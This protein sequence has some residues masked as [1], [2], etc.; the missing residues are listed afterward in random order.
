MEKYKDRADVQFITLNMDE[1]PGLIA[2]YL[3]EH[4]LA[5]PVQRTAM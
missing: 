1:N 3:T 2:P 5:V 4:H